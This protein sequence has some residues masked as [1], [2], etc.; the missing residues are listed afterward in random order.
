M[1]LRLGM[2]VQSRSQAVARYCRTLL[3]HRQKGGAT[4]HHSHLT[5]MAGLHVLGQL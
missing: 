2:M 1:H 3:T 5:L 4:L